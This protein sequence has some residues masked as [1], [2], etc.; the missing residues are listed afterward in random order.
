MPLDPADA[1]PPKPCD[2]ILVEVT[3]G[4]MVESRHAAAYAVCDTEGR[5]VL[6]AGDYERPVYARSAIKPLQA[7]PLVESGAAEAYGLSD[8]EVALACASH[9]GEPRHVEAVAAWLE[10]LGLGEGDLECAA[11]L[12]SYAPAMIELL[13]ASEEPNQLHNN[14]SGKHTGF[15]TL[16]KH[17]GHPTKGYIRYEHPVQQRILGVLEVMTGLDL[18]AAPRGI[19]GCGI[20]TIG[21]PLGNMALAM[22]RFAAPADQPESRQAAVARIHRAIAAEPFMVAGSGRFCTRVIEASGGRALVKTGAEGVYCGAVPSM[23]LGIALKVDDGA[24]RAAENLMARLLHRLEVIDDATAASIGGFLES[25]VE[26]RAGLEVGY[27]RKAVD[28][29]F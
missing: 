24:G 5:V 9:G 2:P 12:P 28:A 10:R 1:P 4:D 16:A 11:H 22:A 21:I 17:L 18:S 15:L 14:C 6:S 19:D 3:R 8:A 23:G 20:P 13:Q 27:T 25:P 26:N 29:P 7:I